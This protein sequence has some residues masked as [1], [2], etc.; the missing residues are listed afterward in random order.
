MLIS[1]KIESEIVDFAL[2]HASYYKEVDRDALELYTTLHLQFGTMLVL[3]DKNGIAIVAR[4]NL[5][6]SRD[7]LH[8]IDLI[9]RQDLRSIRM[10]RYCAI[11][12]WNLNPQVSWFYYERSHRAERP[13]YGYSLKHWLKLKENSH[14]RLKLT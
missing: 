4:W 1:Q 12:I 6:P 7:T 14:G 13:S 8:L 3:R 11:Q 5:L 9:V 2:R 10:L